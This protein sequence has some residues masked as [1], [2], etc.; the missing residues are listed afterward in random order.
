[1]YI[2]RFQVDT[3]KWDIVY[4]PIV[5]RDEIVEIYI[6]DGDESMA[7][8]EAVA[9]AGTGKRPRVRVDITGA[10]FFRMDEVAVDFKAEQASGSDQ[11]S[12]TQLGYR[13]TEEV[14]FER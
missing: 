7:N 6:E 3:E 4:Q 13:T 1:M 10:E 14:S 9:R 5:T 12:R 8:L 11:S 2:S